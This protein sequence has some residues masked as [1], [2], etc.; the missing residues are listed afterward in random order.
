M[1]T[2][3]IPGLRARDRRAHCP[4]ISPVSTFQKEN[5][6]MRTLKHRTLSIEAD[7][8]VWIAL[9]WQVYSNTDTVGE[10]NRD[11]RID[12]LL[13]TGLANGLT[14]SSVLAWAISE[15]R[16]QDEHDSMTRAIASEGAAI[17]KLADA[18]RQESED[19]V[20]SRI[21]SRLSEKTQYAIRAQLRR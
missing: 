15:R 7:E 2:V 5:R 8:S 20:L 21:M 17:G 9:G 16:R 10:H 14:G 13:A 11:Y 1:V 12:Q 19:T 18:L 6:P 3:E 4:A